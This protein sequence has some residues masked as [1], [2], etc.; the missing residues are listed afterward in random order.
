MFPCVF[1]RRATKQS[2]VHRRPG[3][4]AATERVGSSLQQVYTVDWPTVRLLLGFKRLST[5]VLLAA[6]SVCSVISVVEL[7]AR[8]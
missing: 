8:V 1:I 5:T 6:L 2:N 3:S 7:L 4:D